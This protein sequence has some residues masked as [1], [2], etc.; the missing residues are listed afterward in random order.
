MSGK[1]WS[2]AP[3]FMSSFSS[4]S[5]WEGEEE[6]FKFEM[7]W[8][9]TLM[10]GV[11]LVLVGGVRVC[12]WVG[13]EVMR[14]GSIIGWKRSMDGRDICSSR[15]RDEVLSM[16]R[17]ALSCNVITG[18]LCPLFRVFMFALLAQ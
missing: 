6:L 11:T 16:R 1:S 10:V 14:I 13:G 18:V 4:S 2:S 15:R 3:S 9:L 8:G 5:S 7:G 17:E 12:C